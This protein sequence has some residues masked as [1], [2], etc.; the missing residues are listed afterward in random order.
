MAKIIKRGDMWYS[1]LRVEGKRVR[2][3]LSKTMPV[4]KKMLDDII[5]M[6]QSQ[7]MGHTPKNMGWEVFKTDFLRRSQVND[8]SET[9]YANRRAFE[10]VDAVA[11]LQNLHQMTPEK[12]IHVDTVLKEKN[13]PPS[14]IARS[15]RAIVTAMRRA[16]D[17]KLVSPQNWR[18]VKW[19][20]PKSRLDFYEIEDFR[21]LILKLSGVWRTSALLMGRAGLRL[22]EALH[23]EWRDVQFDNHRIIFRSKPEH[24]WNIK[25]DKNGTKI[26]TVPMTRDLEDHLASLPKPPGFVLGPECSRSREVYGKQ[27]TRALKAT[28]VRTY[29]GR[30]GFPH[31]LRHTFGS[32][33]AQAG[34]YE[35]TIAELMGHSTTK[36]VRI[37]SHLR[38]IDLK[39]GVGML[40]ALSDGVSTFQSSGQDPEKGV[41]TFG[42]L[43][44][45]APR[46]TPV[47]DQYN[48]DLPQAEMSTKSDDSVR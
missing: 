37:Y 40:P 9:F 42:P 11:Y 34:V 44:S 38:P 8:A 16:E 13:Y 4:A 45:V 5:H 6:R 12:L 33:L 17:M 2:V 46:Y 28:G 47:L 32:H 26:R 23:L 24:L 35:G 20:E 10:L 21:Q 27:V 18:L 31:I 43:S 15:I 3:P 22:G 36:M 41:S 30:Y 1:D 14:T 19:T 39:Q 25:G 29:L 48:A 7:R